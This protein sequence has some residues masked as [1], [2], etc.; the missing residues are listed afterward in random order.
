MFKKLTARLK[1]NSTRSYLDLFAKAA[2]LKTPAGGVVLD[3]GAGH[4]PYKNHFSHA[5]YES[6]DFCEIKKAYGEITHICS[7]TAIPVEDSR[8]DLVFCSQTLE[9]VPEPKC[10]LQEFHRVLK[11][12]GELWLTAPFFF[13]EHEIPH[14]FYRYTQ[15]GF[16]Y[17]LETTGFSV[18]KIEWLEGYYGTLAYQLQVAS[19]ALSI[20][21]K[22]YGNGAIGIAS[23]IMVFL[24][25]PL[26]MVA[27]WLF[28]NLD[29]R[30]KFTGSGQCKNYA[31]VAIKK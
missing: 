28:S 8:Y 17:L 16:T 30:Y 18:K 12:G 21:P 31:I 27:S 23:V 19:R 4:C 11:H 10:V 25:K 24:L 3:A 14:D 7:L 22:H 13:T 6:A 5:V 9:H 15:Y 2:A 29:L 1:V 20:N 26:F